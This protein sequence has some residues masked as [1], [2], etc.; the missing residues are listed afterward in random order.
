MSNLKYNTKIGEKESLNKDK[1]LP[2][3]MR[4][5]PPL[6]TKERPSI[7][8]NKILNFDDTDENKKENPNETILTK[9]FLDQL[10]NNPHSIPKSKIFEIVSNAMQNSHL[11]EK[12]EDDNKNTKKMNQ[13]DLSNA[14]AKKFTFEKFQRGDIIF[15]IGDNGDK[16]YYVLK[17]KAN[18]LKIKEIPN[19]YMSILEYI[20]YCIY[21]I[22]S[23]E[24]YLFQEVIMTNIK[25]LKVT[26]EEEIMTLFKISFKC[27]LIEQLNQHII[28]DNKTLEDFFAFN[29]QDINDYNL[30]KKELEVLEMD[31]N[32]R[33]ALGYIHWKNYIIKKC[34]LTTRELI[35]YEQ[36]YKILID[37]QKKKISCLVY[38]SLLYLGPSTYFGDTAFD[39]EGN[40]RNATIRAEEDTYVACLRASDYLNIIAPKRRFEKTKAIAFLFNTFFFQQI[41]PHIFERNYFHLFYLKEYPKNTILFDCGIMPKNLLLVKEGQIS[42]DLKISVLEIHNLIKFLFNNIINNKYFQ[43][44]SKSKKNEILSHD[45]LNQIYKYIREPKLDRLKMQSF[46]FVQE[47]NRIQN[48]R[49]TI[50]MGVEAVGLE[51]IFLNIPYL[52]KGV[53]IKNVVCYELAVD[54]IN[55]MLKEE[56]QIKPSYTIKSVKKILTLIERL[57][58]IKKNCVDMASSKFNIHNDSLFNKIFYS[59]QFPLLRSSNSTDN[60][61]L[62]NQSDKNKNNY[63][64]KM[65][66]NDNINYKEDIGT[67]MNR[68]SSIMKTGSPEKNEEETSQDKNKIKYNNRSIQTKVNK[69]L[70]KKQ[71]LKGKNDITNIQKINSYKTVQI[72]NLKE[73]PRNDLPF[74]KS[75]IR[76]FRIKNH[77]DYK[78]NLLTQFKNCKYKR[79]NILEI[80]SKKKKKKN[81]STF[82]KTFFN[83]GF[84]NSNDKIETNKLK[85]KLNTGIKTN[86]LF[87]LGDNKYCTIKKLKKQIQEFNTCDNKGK[88]IEIIQSNEIIN[89]YNDKKIPDI[90]KLNTSNKFFMKKNLIKFAQCFNNFHLSFVPISVKYNDQ[91]INKKHNENNMNSSGNNLRMMRNSSYSEKFFVN[92]NIKNYFIINKRNK[93]N[94][95]EQIHRVNSDLI[96]CH[97]DLPKIKNVFFNVNKK[98]KYNTSEKN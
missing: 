79:L 98:N 42:L 36:Y 56:K 48:F 67:I 33:V 55:L 1:P 27:T 18:I 52:M 83:E 91:L 97:K 93:I 24:Y 65:T 63:V 30:D 82:S 77:P 58:S 47:M 43:N 25:I 78:N 81:N 80:N 41:N 92:K 26:S 37:Q 7:T 19:I 64:K 20:K 71:S 38:E 84:D 39:F 12:V 35:F 13:E 62:Y 95:R 94:K 21:L 2:F 66:T 31:K 29:E 96:E 57:Q 6:E 9:Q 40:K 87:L 86:N 59:T 22:K 5:Y 14:F 73:N 76:N 28:H 50:L 75:P 23:G 15:R 85:P 3:F 68:A 72:M 89:G 44:L 8:I 32:N 49:I 53:V 17:G 54:K 45:V 70:M 10:V 90:D 60:M 69:S 11:I 61:I 4:L 46:R 74:F 16:F 34:E 88:K 51:E